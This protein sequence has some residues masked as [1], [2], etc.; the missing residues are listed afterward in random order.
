VKVTAFPPG[1]KSGVSRPPLPWLAAL[2]DAIRKS[3]IDGIFLDEWWQGPAVEG[4]KNDVGDVE[5][6]ECDVGEDDLSW[7]FPV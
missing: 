1:P 2:L 7:D 6:D 4:G 5:N 3:R